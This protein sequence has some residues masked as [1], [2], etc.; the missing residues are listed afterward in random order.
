MDLMKKNSIQHPSA[1][2]QAM[3]GPL[4]KAL[5]D[6][7]LSALQHGQNQMEI[8]IGS[9]ESPIKVRLIA[10]QSSKMADLPL[11]DG[12]P[13]MAAVFVERDFK[14]EIKPLAEAH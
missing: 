9:P 1:P 6:L 11:E 14:K 4:A 5:N 7:I 12:K 2:P 13:Q 8:A 3:P 10:V